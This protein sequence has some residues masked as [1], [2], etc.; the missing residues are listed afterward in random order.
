MEYG[1][2]LGLIILIADIWAIINVMG[3]GA[4]TGSK[5]IWTILILVLPVLGLIIWLFA[6]PRSGRA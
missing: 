5:I 6:G 2:I 4:S 1:G 3:S